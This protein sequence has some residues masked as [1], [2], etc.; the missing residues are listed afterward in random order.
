MTKN[1]KKIPPKEFDE[2][3]DKVLTWFF[4]FPN[5]EMTLSNLA[6][7]VKISKTTANRVVT[8]LKEEGFL[9]IKEIG[10]SWLISC[11]QHHLF[12]STRKVIYNL[13]IIYDA[14]EKIIRES[15][16]AYVSNPKSVILFGSYRKG[17]D[18]EK[19]DL[20]IAVEV[21]GDKQIEIIDL[22]EFE[23][24]GLRKNVPINLH[25]F[26]RKNIDINLFSNIVNGIILDGFLEVKP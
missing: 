17:D 9:L 7:K 6:K 14:Y 3:Y 10:K 15:L 23:Q 21:I 18:T 1:L 20:D 12:N 19:S 5:T 26:S 4:S 11:N 13:S 2:G 22:G 24:F 16:Y 8:E 25:V